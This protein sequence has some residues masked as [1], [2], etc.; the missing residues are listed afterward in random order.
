MEFFYCLFLKLCHNINSGKV[1]HTI[2]FVAYVLKFQHG[3]AHHPI[4][5]LGLKPA[6][7][8]QR[9]ILFVAYVLKFQHGSAHHPICCLG[10]KPGTKVQRT[11]LFVAL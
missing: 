1:H 8:V 5:C 7:K 4:R 6:T 2:L 10:L 3:S 11:V 9:T